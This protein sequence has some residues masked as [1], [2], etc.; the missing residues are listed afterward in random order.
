M[1]H[2]TATNNPCCTIVK[3]RAKPPPSQAKPSQ[4]PPRQ[5]PPRQ[6]PLCHSK[7]SVPQRRKHSQDSSREGSFRGEIVQHHREESIQASA[8]PS[9]A[10]PHQVPPSQAPPC[11]TSKCM[12]K[13]QNWYVFYFCPSHLFHRNTHMPSLH[14]SSL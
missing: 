8:K 6:A 10:P 11:K 14:P 13:I 7:K 4:A 2:A 5:A 12:I 3:N 1:W 9:Q